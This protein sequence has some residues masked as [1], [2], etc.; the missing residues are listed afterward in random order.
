MQLQYFMLKFFLFCHFI[1]SLEALIGCDI[2]IQFQVVHIPYI[3]TFD[4]RTYIWSLEVWMEQTTFKF[5]KF[6]WELVHLFLFKSNGHYFHLQ[7]EASNVRVCWIPVWLKASPLHVFPVVVVE[8]S[9][10]SLLYHGV[11]CGYSLGGL[12]LLWVSSLAAH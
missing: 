7:L 5:L 12:A 10:D 11:P 6:T 9:S 1:S 8:W 2:M 4:L 3:C